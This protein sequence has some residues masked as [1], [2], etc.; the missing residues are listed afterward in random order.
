MSDMTSIPPRLLVATTLLFAMLCP[1][2]HGSPVDA[3]PSPGPVPSAK[4]LPDVADIAAANAKARGGIDAWRAVS[5][6]SERGRIEHGQLA[7]PTSR[8]AKAQVGSRELQ[9]A[10][11]FMLQLKRPHKMRVEMSLGD[12]KALQLFDGAMGYLLQPSPTG[13][14]IRRYT[15]DEAAASAE[16]VDPE[17]PLLDAAAKGTAVTLDGEDTVE[18][19]RTYKLGLTLHNGLQR[20]LWIDADTYLD[21]KIDGTRIIDGHPWPVETYFYDWRQTG[22][23]KLPY[24]V[25]TAI[26][27]VR[28]S[29]RI[30]VERVLVNTPVDDSEFSLP[31]AKQSAPA[32]VVATVP[33]PGSEAPDPH[34]A[35]HSAMTESVTRREVT[36]SLPNVQLVRQD[37]KRISLEQ[38]LGAD[39]PVLVNFVYTTCTTIC[40]LSSQVFSQFQEKLAAQ[41]GAAHLVSI[42]IDPEQDTPVRLTQ[43]AH[44]FHAGPNWDHF[45]GTTEASIAVQ[46]AFDVYRGDKM[47]HGA[48][49]LLRAA[50]GSDW[51]RLDGFATADDLLG[52]YRS[53][54]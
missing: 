51:I 29:S 34:A 32:A 43:Y 45:T 54:R 35:H 31:V 22:G 46:R 14:L 37:G 41:H 6:L 23:V 39:R 5:T 2:A 27:D 30:I 10:L 11:P 48:V 50:H 17:G 38:A 1:P 40:P 25:E 49:T 26:D 44:R 33:A 19:R 8:H 20:H 3:A 47:N 4:I 16:Q 28:T 9:E 7:R 15:P 52:A 36:Y 53:L 21:V 18:G 24:R 12:T 42:S 13:P